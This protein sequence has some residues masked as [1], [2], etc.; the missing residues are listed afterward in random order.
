MNLANKSPLVQKHIVFGTS[1]MKDCR[2]SLEI[3]AK[4]VDKV[5]LVQG[6]HARCMKIEVLQE[7][8]N[9]IEEKIVGKSHIFQE[10]VAKGDISKTLDSILQRINEEKSEE[11]V[12]IMGS[13]FI[14]REVMEYFG[15]KYE[16]DPF[17]LN[18]I[19]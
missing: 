16:L 12:V 11:M 15:I 5:S 3:L 17:E 13:F 1:S 14:M 4:Y 19:V 2:S 8:K 18:E 7:V 6:K 10:V 9:E